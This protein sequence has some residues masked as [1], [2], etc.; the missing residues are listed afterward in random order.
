MVVLVVMSGG[1]LGVSAGAVARWWQ[2]HWCKCL[3]ET[4]RKAKGKYRYR[5]LWVEQLGSW[6][7][8]SR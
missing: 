4:A 2:R 7:F 8:W 1:G 5:S 3:R 6:F